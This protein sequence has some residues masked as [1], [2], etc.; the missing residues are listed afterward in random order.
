MRDALCPCRHELRLWVAME[1]RIMRMIPVCGLV[2]V[3][4][5]EGVAAPQIESRPANVVGNK[6]RKHLAI[7]VTQTA[8]NSVTQAAK[9]AKAGKD[10]E[11]SNSVPALRGQ[12]AALAQAVSNLSV[13]VAQQADLLKALS[14]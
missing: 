2:F 8:T 12:V 14:R 13:I 11:A 9:A 6:A 1:D 10:A 3:L 4:A 7:T 5:G